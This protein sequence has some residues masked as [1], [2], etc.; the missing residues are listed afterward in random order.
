[1]TSSVGRNAK[2][3]LVQTIVGALTVFVLYKFLYGHLG[4]DKLGLWT[5]VL[6]SVSVGRLAELGL[7]T[8]VLRFVSMHL[9]AGDRARAADILET[10]IVSIGAPFALILL[11][12]YPLATAAMQYVV[13]GEN[14][15]GARGILPFA[16]ATLWFGVTGTIVQSAL[17]GCGRMDVKSRILIVGNLVYV[18]AAI[19]MVQEW[20]IVGL[21]VCQLLQAALVGVLVWVATRRELPG[22]QGAPVKWDRSC[23]REII[24]YAAGLQLGNLLLLLFEPA[25]KILLSRYCGLSEVAHF[26]MANQVVSRVRG[27]VTS[28][29]QAYLPV[30][31]STGSAIDTARGMVGEASFFISRLGLPLMAGLVISYPVISILWIDHMHPDFIVYG[32]ILGT[33]WLVA[34]MAMP[35]YYYCV[36]AGR[37]RAILASQALTVGLNTVLGF[38]AALLGLGRWV[39]VSMMVSLAAGNL[40]TTARALADLGTSIKKILQIAAARDAINVVLRTVAVIAFHIGVSLSTSSYSLAYANFAVSSALLLLILYLSHAA[41]VLVGRNPKGR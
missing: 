40:I 34:T 31:S 33:G 14:V 9:A 13:P 21:A 1:M 22:L 6:A 29:M 5:V 30:L 35:T 25:T 20:G 27:L 17:D 2:W 3:S 18:A 8:T 41:A 16:F 10:G 11:I 23:F 37:I 24:G 7:S 32:W 28:A 19:L 39:A 4:P 12:C 38:S 15:A 26:E 36:G